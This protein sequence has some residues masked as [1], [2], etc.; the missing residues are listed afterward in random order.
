MKRNTLN[1][2]FTDLYTINYHNEFVGEQFCFRIWTALMILRNFQAIWIGLMFKLIYYDDYG[3]TVGL[4][5]FFYIEWYH[6]M[7]FKLIAYD[8]HLNKWIGFQ[9][10][11]FDSCLLVEIHYF[12]IIITIIG[13]LTLFNPLILF[14]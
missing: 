4:K 2:S 5:H 11:I 14:V 3:D 7:G 12:R 1:K 13:Y 6:S 9:L 8:L 10:S